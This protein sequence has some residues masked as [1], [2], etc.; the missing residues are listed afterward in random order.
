MSRAGP[1]VGRPKLIAHA[2]IRNSGTIQQPIGAGVLRYV[3]P[4]RYAG[5]RVV[6]KGRLI[7]RVC[8]LWPA[9]RPYAVREDLPAVLGKW[10][11]RALLGN[12]TG[13]LGNE[14][15]ASI[16][17]SSVTCRVTGAFR[18]RAAAP[19]CACS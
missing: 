7:A 11:Q 2:E 19:G 13:R 16:E 18:A 8:L 5:S 10:Q 14:F 17:S 3:G 4:T 9:T 6:A 1:C 12:L 15:S